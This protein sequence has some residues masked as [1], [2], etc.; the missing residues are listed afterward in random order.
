MTSTEKILEELAESVIIGD[1]SKAELLAKEAVNQKIAPYRAIIDGC[2]RGMKVCSEKFEK[3]EYYVPDLLVA[4]RAMNTAIAV[5]KPHIK[6]DQEKAVGKIVLGTV[7]GDVHDI[8]KNIV[9]ILLEAAG[10]EVIDLGKDVS[11][12]DFINAIN[13]YKPQIVGLSTLMSPTMLTMKESIAE[14]NKQSLR[15]KFKIIVG[16]APITEEYAKE[17]GADGYA[18]D[19]AKAVNLVKKLLA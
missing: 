2:G 16:G 18:E 13:K 9:K 3:H 6:A 17:I 5:L 12:S 7:E 11:T 15:S 14:L 4:A 10:V 8:G 1:A 19:A